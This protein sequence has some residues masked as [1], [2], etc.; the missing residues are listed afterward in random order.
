[1]GGRAEGLA[2]ADPVARTPIGAS[3]N[4]WILLGEVYPILVSPINITLQFMWVYVSI[5]N[6]IFNQEIFKLISVLLKC[7]VQPTKVKQ[8]YETHILRIAWFLILYTFIYRFTMQKNPP[9]ISTGVGAISKF[10]HK[11]D[12]V[13]SLVYFLLQYFPFTTFGLCRRINKQET[14]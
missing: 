10:W 11:L 1:M 6:Q 14:A 12:V 3:G 9:I 8:D 5:N 2:C 4:L 13:F 7:S